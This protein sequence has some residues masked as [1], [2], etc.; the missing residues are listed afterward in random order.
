M[1]EHTCHLKRVIKTNSVCK[2]FTS[3]KLIR[4]G[5]AGE[6]SREA[7]GRQVGGGKYLRELE[8]TIVKL[9]MDWW[10]TARGFSVQLSIQPL[11]W[12]VYCTYVLH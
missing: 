5:L 6:D 3:Q 10:S 11:E 1:L 9:R 8:K 12:T 2:F 7:G 4:T